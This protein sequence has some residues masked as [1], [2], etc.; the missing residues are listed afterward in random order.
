MNIVRRHIKFAALLMLATMICLI[1]VRAVHYHSEEM[2]DTWEGISTP[3]HD[4]QCYVCQFLSYLA[5]D[6][7]QDDFVY[8]NFTLKTL[9][10]FT[11]LAVTI[12][13]CY[14]LNLRGP[15]SLN[16]FAK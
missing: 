16:Q 15:P 8:F 13:H 7:V 4:S 11:I 6:I 3:S 10:F 9:F 14:P 5:F 2:H 12:L 1:T